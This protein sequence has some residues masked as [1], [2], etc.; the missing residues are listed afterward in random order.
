MQE[1][2]SSKLIGG[3]IRY[4]DISTLLTQVY[5]SNQTV[6]IIIPL[7]E[8][9]QR[10]FDNKNNI[11]NIIRQYKNRSDRFIIFQAITALL[12]HYARYMKSKNIVY[13]IYVCYGKTHY[14]NNLSSSKIEILDLAY[15]NGINI[16][17]GSIL[18]KIIKE[19]LELAESLYNL[20]PLVYYTSTD[21]YDSTISIEYILD[22]VNSKDDDSVINIIASLD[23]KFYYSASKRD[24]TYL[25]GYRYSFSL[26][27]QEFVIIGRENIID[28]LLAS[29]VKGTYDG[30]KVL[31][32]N[33]VYPVIQ[34]MLKTPG[35]GPK[36]VY[37]L[38][39]DDSLEPL[40]LSVLKQDGI[41]SAR[42]FFNYAEALK[43]SLPKKIINSKKTIIELNDVVDISRLIEDIVDKDTLYSIKKVVYSLEIS[44][45]KLLDPLQLHNLYKTYFRINQFKNLLPL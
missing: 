28:K 12:N 33:K 16:E 22:I 23:E 26:R 32:F 27:R 30:Y 2:N 40:W 29:K 25:F 34:S 6:N 4:N 24:N 14:N 37:N 39:I 1:I 44:N 11:I 7:K 10:M 42:L 43:I 15:G 18:E 9:L 21:N 45:I 5:S 8:L 38:L 31:K 13:N 41:N 36:A 35:I 3:F 19:N 20:T 17:Q